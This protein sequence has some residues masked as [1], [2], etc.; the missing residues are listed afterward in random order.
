VI[1]ALSRLVQKSLIAFLLTGVLFRRFVRFN[2]ESVVCDVDQELYASLAVLATP[3]HVRVPI[4]YDFV[5]SQM[6]CLRQGIDGDRNIVFLFC[7]ITNIGN[8]PAPEFD[9]LKSHVFAKD[10]A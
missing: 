6:P 5:D 7:D 3:T 2:R 9:F 1:E 4:A 8:L 10:L